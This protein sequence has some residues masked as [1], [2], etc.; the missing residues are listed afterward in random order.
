MEAICEEGEDYEWCS[1]YLATRDIPEDRDWRP[2]LLRFI[3]EEG[4][5]GDKCPEEWIW[6]NLGETLF[7]CF[8]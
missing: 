6:H 1:W 4:W 2:E 7:G 5:I 3:P 8:S